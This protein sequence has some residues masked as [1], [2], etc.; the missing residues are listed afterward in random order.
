MVCKGAPNAD[1]TPVCDICA[2]GFLLP[3]SGAGRIDTMNNVLEEQLKQLPT[4]PG[5]YKYFSADNELIYV[6]KAVN[7]KNRVKSY[8]NDAN[9]SPKTRILVSQIARLE[10]IIVRSEMDALILEANLIKE[11]RPRFNIILKD[12][13]SHL[14]IKISLNEDWPRIGTCRATDMHLEPKSTYF[15][16]FPSGRI[17]KD[18]LRSLR[19]IFPYLAHNQPSVQGRRRPPQSY[20]Y[21][22]LPLESPREAVDKKEYRRQIF[23]FVRFLEGKRQSV[24]EELEREM[25]AAAKELRFE[26]AASIKKQLDGMAYITQ[27][28]I[29]PESYISNPEIMEEK[30]VQ[31]LRE[32][33]EVLAVY[34]PELKGEGGREKDEV[35]V[36][37]DEA[38]PHQLGRIECYDISNISGQQ[39][40]GSMVV[41]QGGEPLKS[42]Y[43]K[44]KIKRE[45]APNDV[46]MMAEVLRR[47][48]KRLQ[49]GQGARVQDQKQ[50][51][52]F[53]S[54]PNLI[55]VD[56][57]KGQLSA[58][59]EVLAEFRL[60]IPVVGM[61]KREEELI[62]LGSGGRGQVADI[63]SLT[64]DIS[65]KT[66]TTNL[67][68]IKPKRSAAHGAVAK[69][70]EDEQVQVTSEAH[71]TTIRLARGSEAL[72]LIQRIR[73]EAHRFAITYHRKLRAKNFLPS[74]N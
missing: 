11:H 3:V 25:K 71:F 14:Y 38:Y 35:Q 53:S 34:W 55:M 1:N 68:P 48:L 31:G 74:T 13:K 61:T 63:D 46:A 57:G 62:I 24:V 51:E 69:S 22:N 42:D 29:S 43:R 26:Q 10:F 65:L 44:F 9:H 54:L 64:S 59:Y 2:P 16:P 49:V 8:F 37:S 18:T 32:L 30:R 72:F 20:F 66:E 67:K 15:G 39:A 73:D 28:S 17:V 45:Q 60:S 47:R 58:A 6:G 23:Q 4:D 21:Y 12:D 40:V 19:R 41:F 50:D 27:R 56:G 5:I 7:L 52:S 33:N 70:E 36:Q